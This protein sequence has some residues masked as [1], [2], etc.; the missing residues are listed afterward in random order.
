M[1]DIIRGDELG[2]F[3]FGGSTLLVIFEKNRVVFDDDLIINSKKPIETL[4][5][6]GMSLGKL[7]P[8]SKS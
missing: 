8:T 1:N 2:Y 5:K 6:L 4:V 7:T 3:A